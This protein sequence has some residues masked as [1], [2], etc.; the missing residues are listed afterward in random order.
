LTRFYFW[1]VGGILSSITLRLTGGVAV[2]V[3]PIVK[4]CFLFP[5]HKEHI[6]NYH[7]IEKI[8]TILMGETMPGKENKLTV[9]ICNQKPIELVDFTECLLGVGQQYIRFLAKNPEI[10]ESKDIRLYVKEVRPGSTI[11]DLIP[12]APYALP[13]I[14][15]ANSILGFAGYMLAFGKF[16]LGKDEKPQN[17]EK[18]DYDQFNKIVNPIAKDSS[19]QFNLTAVINGDVKLNQTFNIG[20]VEANAIQNGIAR[21]L[22]M[23]KA[24]VERLQ[25][26]VL[27]YWYQAR[28][29]PKSKFGD[30][31]IIESISQIPV[32]T[33]FAFD[34]LKYEMMFGDKSNPFHYAYIVDVMV[35]T[36]QGKAAAYKIIEFHEK[37]PKPK[38]EDDGRQF[39]LLNN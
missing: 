22:Q 21:Q 13:I 23:L 19:S 29:D 7:I 37:F 26:K 24:P 35:D 27:L 30:M 36:I 4:W 33:I 20:H 15:N 3:P 17:I 10:A 12:L 9:R 5:F 18:T 38:P 1:Q 2:R 6:M 16:L 8:G 14:E 34:A 31:S 28:N 39:N 32:K 11:A 25:K